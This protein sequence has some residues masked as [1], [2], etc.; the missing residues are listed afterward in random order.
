MELSYR[1]AQYDDISTLVTFTREHYGHVSGL[2]I[3]LTFQY[4]MTKLTNRDSHV[5]CLY[6]GRRLLGVIIVEDYWLRNQD[7]VDSLGWI[8]LACIHSGYRNRGIFTHFI[9]I[10]T[11][12]HEI[13]AYPKRG[14]DFKWR[15]LLVRE[16]P[17]CPRGCPIVN[18]ATE[19]KTLDRIGG[20]Y[21]NL[22]TTY[23]NEIQIQFQFP[24]SYISSHVLHSHERGNHCYGIVTNGLLTDFVQFRQMIIREGCSVQ[25]VA[26]LGFWMTS[27]IDIDDLLVRAAEEYLLDYGFRAIMFMNSPHNEEILL[28]YQEL[29]TQF[30]IMQSGGET[31]NGDFL[32]W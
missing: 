17:L 5:T 16:H 28:P 32:C 24:P 21:I 4:F 30:S 20:Q 22:M 1:P 12:S 7:G 10:A 6:D 13:A 14:V 18:V 8:S 23:C 25:V 9:Q 3:Q 29:G 31:L 19:T 27:T 26:V 15:C 11:E 2:Q